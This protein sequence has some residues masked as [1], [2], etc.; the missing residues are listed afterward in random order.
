VQDRVSTS[1][2]VSIVVAVAGLALTAGLVGLIGAGM[3]WLS[4]ATP[5]TASSGALFLFLGVAL[6]TCC[7]IAAWGAWSGRSSRRSVLL[8]A[9]PVPVGCLLASAS[10]V[11]LAVL[12]LPTVAAWL[13]LWLLLRRPAAAAHLAPRERRPAASSPARPSP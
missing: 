10:S 11:D 7:A 13:G 9:T 5:G 12:V 4:S 8:L 2:P 6:A 3:A 1:R